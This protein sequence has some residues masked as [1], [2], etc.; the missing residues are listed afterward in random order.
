MDTIDD[1]RG[2]LNQTPPPA[3]LPPLPRGADAEALEAISSAGAIGKRFG[4][5]LLKRE[6]GRGGMGVVYLAEHAELRRD[7]ALKILLAAD[8]ASDGRRHRFQRE[9]EAAAALHH[10][11]IVAV[12]HVGEE[13][14]LA[15]FTMS[16]IDGVT[17]REWCRRKR[18]SPSRT[19]G[20]MATV[21]DAVGYAHA[22][23]IIHRDLKPE[24]I[25]IDGK[26]EP[27]ILDFGLAKRMDG[28]GGGPSW[29]NATLSGAVIGTP[30]YMSPEQ[31]CGDV[32]KIDVRSDVYSLGVILY[33]ILSGE[34]PFRAD[35]LPG[36]IQKIKDDPPPPLRTKVPS[37]AKDLEIIVAK[38]IAKEPE[39]RYWSAYALKAD[40]E[41]WLRREPIN[42][43]GASVLYR[44]QKWIERHRAAAFTLISAFLMAGG[45]LGYLRY[46]QLRIAR[47]LD[48][49]TQEALLEEQARLTAFLSRAREGP[50]RAKA[51]TYSEDDV[52][53]MLAFTDE[54]VREARTLNLAGA[55]ESV[56]DRKLVSAYLAAKHAERL[57]GEAF[58]T[59]RRRLAEQAARA[60][61]EGVARAEAPLC[62]GLTRLSRI[63]ASLGSDPAE[64]AQS[65][66]DAAACF[67]AALR[68]DPS[69][70]LARRCLVDA[71]LGEARAALAQGELDRAE[72]LARHVEDLDAEAVKALLDDV[73]AAR[74]AAAVER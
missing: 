55:G 56:V 29:T 46:E 9:A 18:P 17:L 54:T 4:D 73:A 6:L 50:A 68:H 28:A 25:M 11:N 16:P 23:G 10:P 31:A 69:N 43:R 41:R 12:H 59:E 8:F 67:T 35:S 44:S 65:Y 15:Y 49:R 22:R 45:S 5:Y 62:E 20:L 30:H 13:R 24:N 40:L 27:H 32:D 71:T 64:E 3:G 21:C 57:V 48:Q 61:A 2:L 1:R 53:A 47:E 70:A 60:A 26:G 74:A 36:L 37:I 66:R 42:A 14:G 63:E 51:R 72:R 33:E 38:A 58:E 52:L 39:R 19:A 34:V 7:V